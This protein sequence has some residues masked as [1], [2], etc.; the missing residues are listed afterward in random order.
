MIDIACKNASRAG[1]LDTIRFTESDISGVL[2]KMGHVSS[3]ILPYG[4]R[5][6][7]EN[8]E[9]TYDTLE[10]IFQSNNLYG[11]VITT[12]DFF[13]KNQTGWSKKESHEWCRKMSVLEENVVE[14]FSR[15]SFIQSRAPILCN[16]IHYLVLWGC[17]L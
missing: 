2:M 4:K 6:G 5:I 15:H 3:P 9:E 14:F 1:V 10:H 13:P 11:W 16:L 17:Y 12:V 7:D 8:L